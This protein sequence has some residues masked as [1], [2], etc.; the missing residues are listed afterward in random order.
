MRPTLQAF[1]LGLVGSALRPDH[2]ELRAGLVL[3][4]M[5]GLLMHRYL[6]GLPP[7]A[8]ASPADITAVLGPVLQHYITGDLGDLPDSAG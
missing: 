3:A 6:L 1:V 8:T 7:L 2:R 4:Q 5:H